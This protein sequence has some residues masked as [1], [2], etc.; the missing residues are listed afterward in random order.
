M[1]ATRD[2]TL[3]LIDTIRGHL[4]DKSEPA[5]TFETTPTF[6]ELIS[7]TTTYIDDSRTKEATNSDASLRDFEDYSRPIGGVSLPFPISS[8]RSDTLFASGCE[9]WTVRYDN[10][11]DTGRRRDEEPGHRDASTGCGVRR[12]T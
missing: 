9:E 2:S 6:T 10:V 12:R 7:S 5:F 1:D 11:L 4:C 3:A 8:F